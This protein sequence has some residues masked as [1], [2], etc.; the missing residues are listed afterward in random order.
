MFGV[1]TKRQLVGRK[2]VAN[3]AW[4]YWTRGRGV[5]C[6][7]CEHEFPDRAGAMRCLMSHDPELQAMFGELLAMRR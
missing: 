2:H 4:R 3:T 6:P 5:L 7:V 1:A